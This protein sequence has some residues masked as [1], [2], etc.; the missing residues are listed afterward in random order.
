MRTTTHV[1]AGPRRGADRQDERR[2]RR[3]RVPR[4]PPRLPGRHDHLHPHRLPGPGGRDAAQE[5]PRRVPPAPGTTVELSG[6]D[7]ADF[8]PGG[9]TEL[10]GLLAAAVVLV[11]AFRSLIAAAVPLIV[12][13]IG[14]AC[15][16]A[17]FTL[18]GHAFSGPAFSVYLTIMLGLGVGIDY[19]LLIVTRFRTALEESKEVEEAVEE[20]MRTAGRSVLFAGLIVIATGAGILLLGPSLGGGVA[21]AAGC[22]V[23][24]VMLAAL[25]L[26]PALL[27]MIGRR[28]DRFALPR[29]AEGCR[30]RTGG[31]GSSSAGPGWPGRRRWSRWWRWPCPRRSCGSAGPTRATGR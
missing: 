24:M 13:V 25:T 22:G 19:A 31:A 12:G 30:C 18:L 28:I 9:V 29:R 1:T 6:D 2:P 5:A 27:G 17:L 7:F 4:R 15:G 23:L 8:T 10:V 14:V 26:L 3:P 21:L 20:A 11:F 16:V